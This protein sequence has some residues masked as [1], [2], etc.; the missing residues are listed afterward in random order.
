MSLLSPGAIRRLGAALLALLV[1]SPA[2]AHEGHDHGAPQAA[3]A[4]PATPRVTLSSETY[5]AVGI[6]GAERLTLYLDR[7]AT[8]EP[9]TDA[10][11]VATLGGEGEV[12]AQAGP[13]GTYV[14]ASPRL[15]GAGPLE[16][17]LA[18]TG[19]AGDDL[20][21]GTLNRPDAAAPA[22]AVPPA[23]RSLVLAGTEVPLAYL[24]AAATLALGFLLGLAARG[25][26]RMLPAA[27]LAVILLVGSAA[28]ALAHEGHDHGQAA[29]TPRATGDT[30]QRLSDGSVFLPKPS[31]RI[32]EV[33]T[34]LTKA[35]TAERSTTLI[36]RV[37][38]DPN[39]SGLV[40]SINGG[41][42]SAPEGGSLP[43]LGQ[44][45]RRGDILA[46]VE[47]PIIAADRATLA[48][49]VGDIEQQ[50]ALAEARLARARRLLATGA[51]TTVAVSDAELEVEGLRRRR[52][53][54]REIRSAPEVLR[55]PVDGI[56]ATSRVVAGQV[57]AAQDILFQVVDP[58]AL[59]VE[60][61]VFHDADMPS[62]ATGSEASATTTEGVRLKLRYQGSSRAMQQ[63]S[64]TV[65]FAVLDPPPN[66][67]L[68]QPVTVAAPSGRAESG[69]VL[70]RDAVVRGGNG[71]TLVWRHG[72]AEQF[73]PLL[74]RTEPFD[75][76]RV[77]VRAGI[78][79]GERVVVRG[80]DLVNQIR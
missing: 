24:A 25:R 29:A 57:V 34:V 56:V 21:I 14:V 8:N 55:A 15:A 46:V 17:V 71:E 58:K 70:P 65:Q 62:A 5:E 10:K 59:F 74:V 80:A 19:P 38:A 40:Q 35:S 1:L 4:A 50:T 11:L 33:R 18:V 9:V 63:Q 68:G 26:G 48:E 54:V 13:N 51:G 77:V 27:G 7:F 30:P 28:L 53:A 45:V 20:L 60:A 61:V 32:L 16:I 66:L 69:I 39:R 37:I 23:G 79:E 75:A 2:L 73:E 76:G 42:V 36:G 78:A 64:V 12:D 6:L 44:N 22:L 72:E 41:R 67:S 31:Q 52:E 49:K 43:Q 47:A 3:P